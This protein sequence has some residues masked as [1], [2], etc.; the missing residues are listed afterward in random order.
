MLSNVPF[1][2]AKRNFF[3]CLYPSV[4]KTF[5]LLINDDLCKCLYYWRTAV[6]TII[7]IIIDTISINLTGRKTLIFIN[8]GKFDML[9]FFYCIAFMLAFT[10]KARQASLT[11]LSDFLLDHKTKQY[12]DVWWC[13]NSYYETNLLRFRQLV[14]TAMLNLWR[15]RSLSLIR[16]ALVEYHT[17]QS[18]FSSRN[19][20]KKIYD[21]HF[22]SFSLPIF[23]NAC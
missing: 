2:I 19:G 14:V 9:I 8:F 7:F 18:E 5:M 17:R 21:F 1:N 4:S 22:M 3:L 11:R 15:L 20:N 6:K 16:I 23:Q 12:D 10:I 13:F